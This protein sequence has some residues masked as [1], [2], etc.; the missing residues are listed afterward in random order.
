M[1]ILQQFVQATTRFSMSDKIM[2]KNL[3]IGIYLLVGACMSNK[4]PLGQTN[5]DITAATKAINLTFQRV[6]NAGVS[7]SPRSKIALDSL[8]LAIKPAINQWPHHHNF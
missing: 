1:P 6:E 2:T 4:F 8:S 3:K 5:V 7:F